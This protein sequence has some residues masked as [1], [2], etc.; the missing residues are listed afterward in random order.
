[1][2]RDKRIFIIRS[3]EGSLKALWSG[4]AQ[5]IHIVY[6]PI[7]PSTIKEGLTLVYYLTY[8]DQ[9]YKRFYQ[10]LNVKASY[11]SYS[12]TSVNTKL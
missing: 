6:H 11:D 7:M 2:N 8:C 5:K 1:M 9:I 12:A 10:K 4:L 3:Q